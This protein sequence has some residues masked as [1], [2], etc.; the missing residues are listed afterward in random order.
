MGG[1]RHEMEYR[2]L[3]LLIGGCNTWRSECIGVQRLAFREVICGTS[4]RLVEF[5]VN[6]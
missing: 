5:L 2:K 3:V 1:V 6:T 4:S